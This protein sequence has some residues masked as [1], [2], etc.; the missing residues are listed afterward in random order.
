MYSSSSHQEDT[1]RFVLTQLLVPS[2]LVSFMAHRVNQDTF[3]ENRNVLRN[4]M[5]NSVIPS[6]HPENM[7]DAQTQ[8]QQAM[9]ESEVTLRNSEQRSGDL[10]FL[11]QTVTNLGV[12]VQ[13]SMA[14]ERRMRANP[15]ANQNVT[16]LG[17]AVENI[18]RTIFSTASPRWVTFW[19]A[20]G[21]ALIRLSRA[22]L[23]CTDTP[24]LVTVWYRNGRSPDL[25]SEFLNVTSDSAI[26]CWI[27]V[28]ASCMFSGCMLGITL[29][30]IS[31]RRTFLFSRNVSWFT[32][33]AMKLTRSDGT[34]SWVSTNLNVSSWCEDEEYIIIIQLGMMQEQ[35]VMKKKGKYVLMC[36][37]RCRDESDRNN[38]IRIRL[39]WIRSDILMAIYA[40]HKCLQ[41]NWADG[42]YYK[43]GIKLVVMQLYAEC[44]SV[45]CR[46]NT[47]QKNM[48]KIMG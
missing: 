37:K 44:E 17:L 16:H 41:K 33:W 27:W 45:H 13:A 15:T 47:D 30:S 9:A 32:R 39:G 7:H 29:L 19:F 8:I 3:R 25:C 12:S 14:R 6:M 26:A 24:R 38:S 43:W 48:G 5:L 22:M 31:F 40:I 4:E 21:F 1:F 11:Y 42:R 2:L 20:V 23:A 36:R 10:P 34:N 35:Y 18:V 46:S 28:C